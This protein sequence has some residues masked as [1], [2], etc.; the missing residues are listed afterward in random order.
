MRGIT[1]IGAI[2]IPYILYKYISDA[3]R[4][5]DPR[6]TETLHPPDAASPS[7]SSNPQD[8]YDVFLSFRGET[9]KTFTSHLYKALDEKGIFKFLDVKR[10]ERGEDISPGLDKA[11][12]GSRC[13]VVVVSGNYASSRWCMDELVQILKCRKDSKIKQIEFRDD[14][15]KVESWSDALRQLAKIAGHHLD[16]G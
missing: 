6:R 13:A 5:R 12:E 9:G 2:S 4:R 3:T 11:I 1:Y 14:E 8:N 7:S 10:L 15:E 16:D